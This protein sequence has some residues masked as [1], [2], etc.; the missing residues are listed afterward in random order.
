MAMTLSNIASKIRLKSRNSVKYREQLD[1]LE[2]QNELMDQKIKSV[3]ETVQKYRFLLRNLDAVH[4]LKL[5]DNQMVNLIHFPILEDF[6]KDVLQVRKILATGV[7]ELRSKVTRKQAT[8]IDNDKPHSEMIKQTNN[9][10]V[11]KKAKKG[12]ILKLKMDIAKLKEQLVEEQ[13]S[14]NE[15]RQ[16]YRQC[17]FDKD[18]TNSSRLLHNEN[19]KIGQHRRHHQKHPTYPQANDFVPASSLVRKPRYDKL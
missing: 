3:E 16:K 6:L 17:Q 7:Q 8:M 1:V 13:K 11:E 5:A 19:R 18:I 2:K 4:F 12:E 14:L 10:D 15:L 9:K